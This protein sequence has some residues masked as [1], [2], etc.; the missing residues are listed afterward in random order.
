MPCPLGWGLCEGKAESSFDWSSVGRDSLHPQPDCSLGWAVTPPLAWKLPGQGLCLPS[1]LGLAH[2]AASPDWDLLEGWAASPPL[3]WVAEPK[4][5]DEGISWKAAGIEK[6]EWEGHWS[7][8]PFCLPRLAPKGPEPPV[9]KW[10]GWEQVN[11]VGQAPIPASLADLDAH[12]SLC[13]EAAISKA[14]R[15]PS[16]GQG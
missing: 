13:S 6:G 1:S 15:W 16:V 11:V 10:V 7:G 8:L 9:Y 2:R 4:V 14:A 12:S 5:P 3:D